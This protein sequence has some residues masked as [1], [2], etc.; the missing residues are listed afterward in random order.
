MNVYMRPNVIDK[1]I[2][3]FSI[4]RSKDIIFFVL[5]YFSLNHFYLS[6][7]C[8]NERRAEKKVELYTLSDR[9]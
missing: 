9:A 2:N 5:N 6:C 1:I 8:L 7:L 3:S 4:E